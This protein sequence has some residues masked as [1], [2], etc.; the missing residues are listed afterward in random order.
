MADF[1]DLSQFLLSLSERNRSRQREDEERAQQQQWRQAQT[2]LQYG[3]SPGRQ[4]SGEMEDLLAQLGL[5]DTL[6][7]ADP[8]TGG[9]VWQATPEEQQQQEAFTRQKQVWDRQDEQYGWQKE[10]QQRKVDAEALQ[11]FRP[12]T[13][14]TQSQIEGVLR[15]DSPLMKQFEFADFGDLESLG[16]I[17]EAPQD[18]LNRR[19][20]QDYDENKALLAPYLSGQQAIKTDTDALR[21]LNAGI[22]GI[23]LPSQEQRNHQHRMAQIEASRREPTPTPLNWDREYQLE[24]RRYS[25]QRDAMGAY[26]TEDDVQ[27]HMLRWQQDVTRQASPENQPPLMWQR[28]DTTGQFLEEITPEQ[29]QQFITQLYGPEVTEEQVRSRPDEY[30]MRP[31]SASFLLPYEQ[32]GVN[33][34]SALQQYLRAPAKSKRARAASA[35]LRLLAPIGG[36]E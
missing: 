27:L 13:P 14:Y 19:K 20:L 22:P 30:P 2:A 9:R 10:D 15:A 6:V 7:G 28:P 5:G 24:R 25:G 23:A 18:I 26:P 34:P 17:P 16:M 33:I 31:P 11:A 29:V 8:L 35:G 1:G 36:K 21:L 3:R 12:G 4:V 32:Q